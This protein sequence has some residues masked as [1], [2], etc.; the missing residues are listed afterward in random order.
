[1]IGAFS[2]Q[3]GIVRDQISSGKWEDDP[4]DSRRLAWLRNFD[5]LRTKAQ[6]SKDVIRTAVNLSATTELRAVAIWVLGR[7]EIRS[8][9]TP[10]LRLLRQPD[11]TI[12]FRAA[13]ALCEIA[14]C[15]IVPSVIN[16]LKCGSFWRSRE[17]AAWILHK[18]KGLGAGAALAVAALTDREPAVRTAAVHG[19]ITYPQKRSLVTI[20]RALEDSSPR[21]R[22]MAVFA[23][24]CLASQ[25]GIEVTIPALKR[26]AGNAEDIDLREEAIET[27]RSL[28]HPQARG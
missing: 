8:A 9:M 20:A 28:S 13:E 17:G 6:N 1:M 5:V 7:L 2:K 23:V 27:I 26:L 4:D 22:R 18:V 24:D 10:L 19:L 25:A 11:D 16:V 21:V 3:V 14:D 15:R 12:S